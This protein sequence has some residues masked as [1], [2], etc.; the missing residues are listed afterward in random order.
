MDGVR[1]ATPDDI[2]RLVELFGMAVDEM[3][4][5]RGGAVFTERETRAVPSRDDLAAAV[6]GDGGRLALVGTYDG[7]VLGYSVAGIEVLRDGTRLGR[8]T[9]LYV[10]PGARGVGVGDRMM[11]EILA[12][13]QA[14]R[15]AAA[16]GYALPG[17]RSTKN[18][19]ESS[20]F[21]ARLLVMHRRF[22][23]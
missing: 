22:D 3:R 4:P 5:L 20:G 15:C 14:E 10:E 17:D 11:T 16:D 1:R 13:F 2:D 8:I 12:W 19:F 9:D 21:S 23:S 6:A 18:F 7:M